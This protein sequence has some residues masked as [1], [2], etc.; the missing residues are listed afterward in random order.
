MK[1]SAK[2]TNNT[3]RA[4]ENEITA[5]ARIEEL[6]AELVAVEKSDKTF[7]MRKR[8]QLLALRN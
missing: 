6:T 2:S 5:A 3:A 7:K 8:R 4:L 1:L